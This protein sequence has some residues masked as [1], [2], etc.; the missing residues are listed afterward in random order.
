MLLHNLLHLSYFVRRKFRDE[1]AEDY[2]QRFSGTMAAQHFLLALS[3]TILVITGFALRFPDAAWVRLLIWLGM[4]E[5]VR[6]II[7]RASG[8]VMIITSVWHL[9]EVLFTPRGREFLMD[10][11]PVLGDVGKLTGNVRFHLTG[12][13]PEPRFERFGYI[14]KMEYWA[15]IWGTLVMVVT[16]LILFFPT[17]LGDAT[18]AWFIKVAETIHYYEAWLATLAIIVWHFYF[19]IFNPAEYPV[20]TVWRHGRMSLEELREKHP[21]M[22]RRLRDELLQYS[23]GNIKEQD[24]SYHAYEYVKRHGKEGKEKLQERINN[25]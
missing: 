16:G 17:L 14:E 24:L 4:N 5:N 7:H 21:A 2:I 3:F 9:L 15:L 12:R 19:V 13:G 10:M 1:Y 25:F 22:H 8:I 11:L 20:S 6:S 23:A 18:P